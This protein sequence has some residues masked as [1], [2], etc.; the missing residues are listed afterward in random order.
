M[1]PIVFALSVA[2]T[3]LSIAFACSLVVFV[4]AVLFG[5]A[6]DLDESEYDEPV[7]GKESVV[8]K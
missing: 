3:Y 6:R 4:V 8:R 2:A 5:V 1:E 7:A